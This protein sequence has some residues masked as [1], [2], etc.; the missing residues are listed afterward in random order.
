MSPAPLLS[1]WR[2]ACHPPVPSEI[3][4]QAQRSPSDQN[5]T[6][7]PREVGKRAMGR[8][9]IRGVRAD[10]GIREGEPSPSSSGPFAAAH[11]VGVGFPPLASSTSGSGQG[12]TRQAS[13]G[14]RAGRI[15]SCARSAAPSCPLISNPLMEPRNGPAVL[16]SRRRPRPVVFSSLAAEDVGQQGG[17]NGD[18]CRNFAVGS[19]NARKQSRAAPTGGGMESATATGKTQPDRRCAMALPAPLSTHSGDSVGHVAPGA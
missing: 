5:G 16:C 1:S 13:C 4:P 19:T 10:G 3:R 7:R 8:R 15:R 17:E 12:G 2:L 11:L 6:G 18:R 9:W 14:N